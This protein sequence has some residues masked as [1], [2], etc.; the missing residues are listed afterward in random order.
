[1]KILARFRKAEPASIYDRIGGHEALE[2]VVENFYVRVLADEQLSGFFTGTNMN[3]LKGK[4]VE[5][6]AA[7]LGGPHP[8][9]GAPMKQVHQGR[10]ITMHHF[11][12]V[13]GHLADALTAA[14]VPSETVSE[15]LGAI[16]PLAPEIAT[17]EAGK[18]T[19]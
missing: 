8:Y 13:A 4:Q 9:T 15:I 16:A 18:V 5:F 2:V 10:G 14:G 7:A 17:G 3:R 12:L 6:F 19:V 11:G 1:M